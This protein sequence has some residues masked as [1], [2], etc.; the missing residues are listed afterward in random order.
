MAPLLPRFLIASRTHRHAFASA[1]RFLYNPQHEP[2]GFHPRRRARRVDARRNHR[3]RARRCVSRTHRADRFQTRQFHSRHRRFGA[4]TR[5]ASRRGTRARHRARR[6]FPTTAAS[7]ILRQNIAAAD[8][9]VVA[10]LDAHGAVLVGKNNLHEFAY[11]VTNENP[12][13]GAARNPWQVDCISCAASPVSNPHTGASVCAAR[14][15]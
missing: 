7:N 11:G 10:N 2:N 4:R 9:A 12:H 5:A 13:F 14:F 6:D 3:A 8:S 15:H 1:R